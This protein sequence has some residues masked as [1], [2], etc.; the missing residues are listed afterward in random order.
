MTLGQIQG[1]IGHVAYHFNRLDE[2]NTMVP[3]SSLYLHPVMNG[4]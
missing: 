2:T 1:Q 3:L 4:L